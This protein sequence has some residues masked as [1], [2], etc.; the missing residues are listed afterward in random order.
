M[1]SPS[2]S[3]PPGDPCGVLEATSVFQGRWKGALI[4]W[5]HQRPHHFGELR[6]TL[7]GVTPKV[8]TRQLRELERDGLVTRAHAATRPPRVVYS[9]TPLGAS[10]V[11]LFDALVAWWREHA[12]E[13]ATRRAGAL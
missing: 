9:L 5:L 10:L 11:P 7:V 6:R 3:A 1:P 2:L 13:I 4:W 8:L 12:N